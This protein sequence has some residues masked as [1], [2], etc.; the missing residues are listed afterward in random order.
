MVAPVTIANNFLY[1]AFMEKID[2]TPLKLQKLIYFL[3]KDYLQNTGNELF[4]EPFETWK[5]G[6]VLP[7]VYC[8]FASFGKDAITKFARDSQ[9]NVVLIEEKGEFETSVNRVWG[10]YKGCSGEYLSDLTHR[11]GSAW[12]KAVEAKSKY[13]QSKDIKDEEELR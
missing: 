6:P 8:E 12:S 7:S 10:K 3:Y 11:K 1:K 4:G 9:N 5:F 2:V 13:I